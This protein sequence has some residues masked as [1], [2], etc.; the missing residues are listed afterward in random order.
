MTAI[1]QD[2]R[3]PAGRVL[4]AIG[5][6]VLA[7]IFASGDPEQRRAVDVAAPVERGDA[8]G[9]AEI[10]VHRDHVLRSATPS[11]RR[12]SLVSLGWPSLS[13]AIG[14]AAAML[15]FFVCGC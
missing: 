10:A 2:Q 8:P 5:W 3:L 7:F 15:T 12:R 9:P 11:R 6:A 13:V 4:E 1:G 14:A